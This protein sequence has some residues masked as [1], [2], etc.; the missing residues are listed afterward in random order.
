[1]MSTQTK[2]VILKPVGAAREVVA[3]PSAGPD[4]LLGGPMPL[5][6]ANRLVARGDDRADSRA[7][8]IGEHRLSGAVVISESAASPDGIEPPVVDVRLVRIAASGFPDS[9]EHA[10]TTAYRKRENLAD[11]SDSSEHVDDA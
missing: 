7:L 4:L 5:W 10:N 11:F 6:P 9:C 1:M 2:P 3:Q 8:H